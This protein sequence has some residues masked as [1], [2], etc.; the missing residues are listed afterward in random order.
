MH[1]R[2]ATTLTTPFAEQGTKTALLVNAGARDELK[3]AQSAAEEARAEAVR[4]QAHVA[5][6]ES[7]KR[8]PLYQRKQEEELQV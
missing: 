1:S 5:D 8:P 3:A 6:L 4:L 2:S 7:R